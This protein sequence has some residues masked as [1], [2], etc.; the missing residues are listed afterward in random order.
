[1]VCVGMLDITR[2][3]VYACVTFE[4]QKQPSVGVADNVVFIFKGL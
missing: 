4:L 3:E 1:M 2:D